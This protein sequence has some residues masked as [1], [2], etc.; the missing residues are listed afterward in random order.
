MKQFLKRHELV[1]FF[2]LTYLLSWWIA[3][4]MNGAILPHGP[5]FAAL[6]LVGMIAGRTGLREYWQRLIRFRAGWWY[7]IGPAII[8]A[9]TGIA[10]VLNILSGASLV[11]FPRLLSMGVFLQLLFFGGQWEEPGWTGYALPKLEE[12][13]ANR[14]NGFWI[15]VLVLG[16][17]RS[18]WHLPL[19]L[20]G[21]LYWFDIFLF[22]F[23]IQIIIAWLYLRS[24]SVPA[25]MVFHFVSNLLAAIM[26]PVFAGVE[27]LLFQALFMFLAGVIAMLLVWSSRTRLG[28]EK[29]AAMR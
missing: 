12:R 22:S 8:L 9:Y 21:N 24:R 15:A 19:F 29:A 14:P 7:L 18:L 25:V 10:F 13:F 20:N 16:V 23:A 5:M 4:L 6:M 17:F 3:P 1:L 27:R 2:P 28:Q 26:F 11:E